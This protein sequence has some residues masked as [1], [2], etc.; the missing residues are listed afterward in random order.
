M[1]AS[2]NSEFYQ[3]LINNL[4]KCS[5]TGMDAFESAFVCLKVIFFWI[6]FFCARFLCH[7]VLA[8]VSIE[9]AFLIDHRRMEFTSFVY[10]ATNVLHIYIK[11]SRKLKVKSYVWIFFSLKA[12]INSNAGN[13]FCRLCNYNVWISIDY[14]KSL[15][16]LEWI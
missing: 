16:V 14:S 6:F 13:F 5:S 9:I 10:L 4:F 1:S 2:I 15:A 12:L 7:S 11:K 8:R 3:L